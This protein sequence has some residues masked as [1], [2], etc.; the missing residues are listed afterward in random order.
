MDKRLITVG[1]VILGAAILIKTA[2]VLLSHVKVDEFHKTAITFI[3]DSSASNQP[4]LPKEI[5]YIKSLCAILDPEDAI[6]ILKTDKSAY[7]YSL[8]PVS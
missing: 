6:K 1:L 3:V 8:W 5:K 4:K 7:L 2:V